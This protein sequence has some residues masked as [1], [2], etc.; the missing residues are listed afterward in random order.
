[1]HLFKLATAGLVA[2]AIG[3]VAHAE[4]AEERAGELKMWRQ[5]CADSDVDLRT[6]YIEKA[7]ASEDVAIIRIC[8][9]L[10]LESS[11]ADIRNL[12]L[13]AAIASISQLTFAATMPPQLA[14]A[15]EE[16]GDDERALQKVEGYY[17]TRIFRTIKNGLVFEIKK[18]DVT[19]GTSIWY[20]LAG[21]AQ[22]SD[23]YK[24]QAT[25]IGDRV[26]W[27]GSADLSGGDCSFQVELTEG[28]ILTGQFQCNDYWKVPISAPL[29]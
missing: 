12:G 18:A 3:S 16:A 27:V 26:S 23:R 17:I 5:Q 1:M 19:A 2:M 29:L 24:G 11:D 6:A 15:Y 10:A 13:R 9:R 4:S 20:P 21:L 22:A 28:A 8:V 7:I 14:Q 25:V